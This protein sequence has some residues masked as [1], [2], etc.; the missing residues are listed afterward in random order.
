MSEVTVTRSGS[1]YRSS[2]PISDERADSPPRR[3]QSEKSAD[4]SYVNRR[5][6]DPVLTPIPL[7]PDAAA[8]PRRCD[9]KV[10]ASVAASFA[11]TGASPDEMVTEGM[12]ACK[13]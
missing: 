6:R 10:F 7:P 1:T 13:L 11:R 3:F 9:F 4:E 8:V 5:V 12:R 2:S